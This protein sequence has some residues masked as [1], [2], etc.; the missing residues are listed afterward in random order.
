MHS[1]RIGILLISF[2]FLS[3]FSGSNDPLLKKRVTDKEYR[4]EFYVTK[5]TAKIRSNRM[6]YWFKAGAIHTS[7]YGVSGELLHDDFEKFYF[8]NQLAE[9]GQF[10]RGLKVG[11]WKTWYPNGVLETYQYYDEGYRKSSFYRYSNQGVLLEKGSYR[12]NKK[13]G[14]W[15]NYATND[16]L[17]YKNDNV[18][19]KK[20]KESKKGNEN[21]VAAGAK[22]DGFFKRI[23]KKKEKKEE[24]EKP[25]SKKET[26]KKGKENKTDKKVNLKANKGKKEEVEKEKKK[27]FFG[28]LFSKKE[29]K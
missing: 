25:K 5:K 1:R 16:T 6:Y 7:E 27:G 11:V 2:I 4:Y 9:K 29:K 8:S 19:I 15:I 24:E 22:K 26:S 17:M 12:A 20:S 23:F 28:R 3:S 18:V 13:Q 10:R 14:K 21:D